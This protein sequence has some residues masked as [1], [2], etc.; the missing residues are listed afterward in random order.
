MGKLAFSPHKDFSNILRSNPTSSELQKSVL[1]NNQNTS[2]AKQRL[3]QCLQLKSCEETA[4]KTATGI[5]RHVEA[6]HQIQG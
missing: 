4:I 1:P 3:K 2:S 6:N 5:R